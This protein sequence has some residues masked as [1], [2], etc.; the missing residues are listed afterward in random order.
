MIEIKAKAGANSTEISNHTEGTL[1]DIMNESLAIIESLM[2]NL[3]KSSE[4]GFTLALKM[5]ADNPEILLG[6]GDS[7]K[8]KFAKM[9]AEMTSKSVI[10][11]ENLN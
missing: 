3:K 1:G 9:M 5:L 11:K 8:D 6:D 4:V 2:G 7:D 10:G